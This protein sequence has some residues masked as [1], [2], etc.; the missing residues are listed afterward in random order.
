M[1]DST[2]RSNSSAHSK[3]CENMNSVDTSQQEKLI[4]VLIVD[5]SIISRRMTKRVLGT[6]NFD[7]DEASNM[8]EVT[9]NLQESYHNS[10]YQMT[11]DIIFWSCS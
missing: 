5:N 8:E 4:R 11:Y 10:S 2:Q 1:A 7:I 6:F 3:E 9:E